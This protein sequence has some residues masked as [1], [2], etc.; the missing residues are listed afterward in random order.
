MR[1]L[2][3]YQYFSFHGGIE[4]VI[5]QQAQGLQDRGNDI[6]ILTS[7]YR[8]GDASVLSTGIPIVRLKA[9]NTTYAKFGVP[10]AIP[11]P[12]PG[13]LKKIW[14]LIRNV[15]VVNVHGHPYPFSLIVSLVARLQGKRIVLTQHNTRIVTPSTFVT[16]AATV[17]DRTIGRINLRLA[18]LIV[19]VS[20]ETGQFVTTV[21]PRATTKTRTIYNGIDCQRFHPSSEKASL[22]VRF[23]LPESGF[24]CLT[25]RR[26]T[27]KNGIDVL[28]RAAVDVID[29]DVLFVIA[30]QGPDLEAARKWANEHQVKNVVFLGMVADVDLPAIYAASDIFVL[31]SRRGEGF[32]MVILEALASGLPVVA[33]RSGGHVEILTP[34]TGLLVEPEDPGELASGVLALKGSDIQRMS[35]HCR[36][37]VE[38]R[39]SWDDNVEALL[40]AIR[41]ATA[42]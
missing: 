10:L 14:V 37:I 4:H 20:N 28:L 29:P 21:E 18:R 1:I 24:F 32:P 8:A 38:Q 39:F 23:G 12:T 17:L 13:N 33:T 11:Y 41:L 42:P 35:R 30:G 15:D 36:Q 26:I 22:R 3:A 5:T 40:Q 34:E 2:I 9:L 27:F 31:P 25:V 16:L 7:R 6:V 19:A